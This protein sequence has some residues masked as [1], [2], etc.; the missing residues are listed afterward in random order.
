MTETPPDPIAA[1]LRLR[2]SDADREK[3]AGLLRDAYAEGRLS[4]VEHEERL[5]EV[6]RATTYADLVP[7][8]HDLPVPPG[9]LTLPGLSNA[10]ALTQPHPVAVPTNATGLTVDPSRAD[11]AQGVAIAVFSGVE[12]RGTWV[13]PETQVCVAVMGGIELDLSTAVLTARETT[14]NVFALMGGVEIVVPEGVAVRMDA[15]GFMGGTAGPSDVAPPGAPSIRITGLAVMGG[16]EV[17]RPK[18][19]RAQ[20]TDS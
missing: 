3:V 10:V 20:I 19:R 15:I 6:Y 7:V 4:P 13:V 12:R 1:A 17:K 9:V 8:L 5:S 18:G 11:Q 14:V 2:A 16:I